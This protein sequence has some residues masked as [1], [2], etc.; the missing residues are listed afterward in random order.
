MYDLVI[1]DES[2]MLQLPAVAYVAGLSKVIVAGDFKQLRGVNTRKKDKHVT[3][4]DW[5]II[6]NWLEIDIFTKAK[7]ADAVDK[8][9]PPEN[10]V[11]LR[12]QYRMEKRICDLINNRFYYG[13]LLTHEST[14]VT[15]KKLSDFLAT[16]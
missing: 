14:A 11:K 7:I 6:Q 9:I 5:E 8:N 4:E 2:S 15:K 16:L 10:L 12:T 3:E 1:I 13:D